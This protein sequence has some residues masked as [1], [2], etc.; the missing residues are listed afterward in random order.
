LGSILS[1]FCI[2]T[3]NFSSH[4]F[5]V[6]LRFELLV[7]DLKYLKKQKHHIYLKSHLQTLPNRHSNQQYHGTLLTYKDALS[8]YIVDAKTNITGAFKLKG[9]NFVFFKYYLIQIIYISPWRKCKIRKL[10]WSGENKII[11]NWKILPNWYLVWAL[12]NIFSSDGKQ[13][14]KKSQSASALHC[15]R[16]SGGCAYTYISVIKRGSV[17]V[18]S[19]HPRNACCWNH[20]H[21]KSRD[22]HAAPTTN[23][24]GSFMST[25]QQLLSGC[26][27]DR[28]RRCCCRQSFCDLHTHS[29]RIL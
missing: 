13:K 26:H 27:G 20:D 6:M 19:A 10:H 15:P 9:R 29:L 3:I 25:L 7:F 11:A 18:L 14:C 12:Q 21:L 2:C 28:A 22:A 5:L 1:S 17:E 16:S 23:T 8:Y 24:G 4:A